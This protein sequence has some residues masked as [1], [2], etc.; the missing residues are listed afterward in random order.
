[1][2]VFFLILL[3]AWVLMFVTVWLRARRQHRRE[4]TPYW[5]EECAIWYGDYECPLCALER[6]TRALRRLPPSTHARWGT[7][8]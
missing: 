6:E 5:C 8:V 3:W 7:D 2:L 1:V 4:L